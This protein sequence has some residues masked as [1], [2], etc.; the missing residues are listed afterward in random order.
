MKHR[1]VHLKT[2]FAALG[3]LSCSVVNSADISS[4]PGS[5]LEEFFTAAIN[6]SPE[7]QIAQENLNITGAQKK[8]A[9]SRLLPQLSA[10]ANVSENR[11]D[12]LN[13]FRE[14][15]GERYF[16]SPTQT[17]FNWQ[18]FSARKQA[19][20]IEDQAEEE[21]YYRLA[22]ILTEVAERYF[23]VLQSEDALE[24]IESEID[25]L[26]NQLDQIQNLF[27]RQLAQITDLYQ[28]RASLAS[29]E[30]ERLRILAE[31]A[32]SREGL[33]S[34]SGLEVGPIF[35]LS[36]DAELPSI[37]L[38]QEYYLEQ[39]REKN[40][41]I[42][43][44]QYAL[45]AADERISERKGAYLPQVSFIAQR[46]DSNVGFDNLPINKTDT[47]YIGFN[48]S[49]P[50]YAGGGNKASVSEARSRRSIA[51][52]ELKAAQLEAR[53]NVRA[54]YL[55]VQASEVQTEAARVLVE[56]TRIAAEAMQQ[57][58]NFGT[59]TSVDV[60][61]ALRDQFQ[62]ERDLQRTRYDHIRYFLALK[63]ETGTLSAEDMIEIGAWFE[64]PPAR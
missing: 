46:Q 58:F 15:D 7:L 48:V 26:T 24:S 61:N 27:D 32:I 23:I 10:G 11:L 42:L 30:A 31:N 43:A 13:T 51:E 37:E 53:E 19:Y 47:T 34:I 2:V 3:W 55:Q 36:Q 45:E 5:T 25:A 52:F 60:L 18:Q 22:S 57:G 12:Q 59:V 4:L 39:T 64:P 35:R 14:F 63:R 1:R 62:A 8:A 56:S 54:A 41:L 28:G 40:H 29:A 16:L 38:S 6:F 9:N 21:Y 49:I 33:R 50:I 17:L 44:R 20:L